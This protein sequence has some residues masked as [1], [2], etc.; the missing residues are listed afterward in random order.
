MWAH[1]AK[2]RNGADKPM[3]LHASED[4]GWVEMHGLDIPVVKVEVR[5]SPKGEYYGWIDKGKTVPE[6]IWQGK[7]LFGVCFTYGPEI[8]EK[9]GK[10]RI[11]TLDVREEER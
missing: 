8:E 4:K 1:R 7:M 10:G 9:A 2:D 5:E 11:L 3:Y 6:M